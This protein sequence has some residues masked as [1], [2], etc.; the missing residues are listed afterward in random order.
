MCRCLGSTLVLVALTACGRPPAPL[1]EAARQYVRLAVALGERD[2]D[3]LD[4]YAGPEA[5]VAGVRSHPP[6]LTEIRREAKALAD[7]LTGRGSAGAGPDESTDAARAKA[8]A[9]DLLAI[10]VRADL[11]A[12]VRRSFDDESRA[13]FGIAP[14]PVD[15]AQVDALR[16]R[17]A[18]RV[19][20][21][22][23]LVDRYAAFAARFVVPADRL[24]SVMQASLDECRRRT[25]QHEKLLP[26]ETATLAFVRDRPWSA[27]S[28][29]LGDGRSTIQINTDFQFTVDQ[30][31]QLACHEGYPGHHARSARQA[32]SRG[33]AS[34]PEQLV[35]LMFSP[36]GLDAE[37]AAMLAADAVFSAEERVQFEHDV[38]FPLAHLDPAGAAAHLAVEQLVADLQIAQAGIARRFLDGELEFARAAAALE[39]RAL[40][41]HAE[42]LLKYLNEYRS[43][44]T[45]YTTGRSRLAARLAACAGTTPTRDRRWSCFESVT[46][47]R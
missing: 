31:L 16:A 5:M 20:G 26:G 40:V 39:D 23:R 25:L 17:I 19:G 1:D 45:T 2:P 29:Y 10:E 11:L 8:L 12:G 18:E 7:S 37:A 9:A 47:P 42:A 13:F 44:V 38:L 46:A 43:Y 33:S 41:P 27:F 3:A 32:P 28:R 15:D 35:Q 6:S 34:R 22:G 30:V 21:G 14:E 36:E 4:F 24:Q